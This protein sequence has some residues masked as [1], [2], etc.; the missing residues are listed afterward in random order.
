M[1]SGQLIEYSIRNVILKKS[2]RKCGLETSHRPFSKK[3]N[4]SISLVDEYVESKV[5][6][7]CFYHI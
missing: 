6:I 7:T 5:L 4:L 1:K 2:C 3:S